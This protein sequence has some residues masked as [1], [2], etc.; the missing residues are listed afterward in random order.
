MAT[1]PVGFETRERI[2]AGVLELRQKMNIVLDQIKDGS[3]SKSSVLQPTEEFALSY[4]YVV[5]ALESFSDVGKIRARQVLDE[6]KISHK[7]KL[8]DLADDERMSLLRR[9]Q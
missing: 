4:I 8:G 7:L 5:K 6:M 1:T 3:R 9:I 2:I